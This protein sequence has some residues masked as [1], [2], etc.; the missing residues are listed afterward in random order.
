MI[1][2]LFTNLRIMISYLMTYLIVTRGFK[3]FS[4]TLLQYRMS[5]LHLIHFVS[6]FQ[7]LLGYYFTSDAE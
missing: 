7:T 3:K 5:C 6:T 4:L 1:N 2:L